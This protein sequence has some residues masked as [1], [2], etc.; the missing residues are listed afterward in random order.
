MIF[1][2][3]YTTF[4]FIS[5]LEG[6]VRHRKGQMDSSIPILNSVMAD[7]YLNNG[8]HEEAR[9]LFERLV[10]KMLRWQFS[11]PGPIVSLNLWGPRWLR[12]TLG[13]RTALTVSFLGKLNLS[14]F[15]KGM[16]WL[17]WQLIVKPPIVRPGNICSKYR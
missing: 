14:L 8:H 10:R 15:P 1:F 17:S 4:L 5:L 13:T 2:Y 9:Q 6:V 3:L 16:S 7:Y 12:E 11:L